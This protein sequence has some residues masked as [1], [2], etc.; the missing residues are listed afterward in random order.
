MGTYIG[1]V[2]FVYGNDGF[3]VICDYSVSLE[4]LLIGANALALQLEKQYS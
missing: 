3:D 1:M 2:Y 4:T